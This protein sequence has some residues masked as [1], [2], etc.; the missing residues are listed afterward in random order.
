M[1]TQFYNKNQIFLLNPTRKDI[2]V[3]LYQFSDQETQYKR[4]KDKGLNAPEMCRSSIN[5]QFLFI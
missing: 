5:L 4:M 1:H 2:E 3:K